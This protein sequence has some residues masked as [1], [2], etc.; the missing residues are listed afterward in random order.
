MAGEPGVN[1]EML[2]AAALDGVRHGFLGRRGGVSTGLCAGLNVGWGSGDERA[3]IAENRR[4]AV[5]AGAP[6][7]ALVALPPIPSAHA[8]AATAP[9]PDDA[10]PPAGRPAP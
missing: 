2:R 3:A 5:E 9:R 6:G 7:A 4:R 8:L 1:V 10:P